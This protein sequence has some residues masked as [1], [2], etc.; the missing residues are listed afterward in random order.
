MLRLMRNWRGL[1]KIVTTFIRAIPA[2]ANLVVLI[3]L[4][5]FMFALLGM[6]LFGGIYSADR[7]YSTDPVCLGGVC[8]DG[9]A[10][11]PYYHFDYCGPAMMTVFILLTGEWIDATE[12]AVDLLGPIASAFF[13]F[14]VLLG[15][16][17]RLSRRARRHPIAPSKPLA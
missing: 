14:V 10:P 6:Q 12:P 2:M 13:I 4:T 9:L 8:T 5:M 1:Y 3:L 17:S 15:K 7:G 16:V 11:K